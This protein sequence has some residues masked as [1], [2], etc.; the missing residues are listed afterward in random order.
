MEGPVKAQ[1]T[2]LGGVGG[3]ESEIEKARVDPFG[4]AQ[5]GGTGVRVAWGEGA[6]GL[7][8]RRHRCPSPTHALSPSFLRI[9]RP[10]SNV[11]R[12]LCASSP[13]RTPIA[14]SLGKGSP[15]APPP[16]PPAPPPPASG[17]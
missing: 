4:D 13:C 1:G 17:S 5:S 3:E 8:C 16:P 2:A 12:Y 15:Q 6:E 14:R 9:C 11:F 10:Q 7:G